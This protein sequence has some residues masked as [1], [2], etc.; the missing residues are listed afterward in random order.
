MRYNLQFLFCKQTKKVV[1]WQCWTQIIETDN[2]RK[3]QFQRLLKSIETY[4]DKKNTYFFKETRDFI[5]KVVWIRGQS[6]YQNTDKSTYCP[7]SHITEKIPE[8]SIQ[9][10]GLSISMFFFYTKWRYHVQCHQLKLDGKTRI[11]NLSKFSEK[12]LTR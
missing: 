6:S 9:A 2:L 12:L 8:W 1:K 11:F 4:R 10:L 7:V 5:F 3:K